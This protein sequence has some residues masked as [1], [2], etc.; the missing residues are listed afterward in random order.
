MYTITH[1]YAW[2]LYAIHYFIFIFLFY[3][4]FEYGCKSYEKKNGSNLIILVF[5][6]QYESNNICIYR[7]YFSHSL[8]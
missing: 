1:V 8:M 2:R 3:F 5:R 7:L 4:F 6:A